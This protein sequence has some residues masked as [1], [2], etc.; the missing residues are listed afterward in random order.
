MKNFRGSLL[1]NTHDGLFNLG[2]LFNFIL[3]RPTPGFSSERDSN[4]EWLV[5]IKFFL[6]VLDKQEKFIF[7]EN[8]YVKYVRRSDWYIVVGR[9]RRIWIFITQTHIFHHTFYCWLMWK[10]IRFQKFSISFNILHLCML[11]LVV[12]FL[13]YLFLCLRSTSMSPGGI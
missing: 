4:L 2:H 8:F 10:F 6:V 3:Y 12:F 13:I 9:S 7:Y 5:E 11:I 1:K